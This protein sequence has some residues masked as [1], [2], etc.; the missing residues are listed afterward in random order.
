METS[1]E[2]QESPM[3]AISF[4]FHD[5]VLNGGHEDTG[6]GGAHADR[7][8]ITLS[9]FEA[10]LDAM[11][12]ARAGKPMLVSDIQH[13]VSGFVPIFLTFDDGGSS[14]YTCIADALEKRG[15]RGHFF[16]TTDYIG[17]SGFLNKD[18][19]RVLH[20]KGH[21]IGTHSCSHPRRMSYLAWDMLLQ[22]WS[23]SVKILS[24]IIGRPVKSGSVPGGYFSRRVA[25]AAAACGLTTLF[26]SEP[27]T[28][29][30][31]VEN[32]MVIGRFSVIKGSSAKVTWNLTVGKWTSH[33]QCV[34]KWNV[35]KLAKFVLG[36]QYLA[37]QTALLN[38]RVHTGARPG[39]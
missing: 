8:K 32:C 29:C 14:A 4:L 13:T 21:V 27:R 11:L 16:V 30:Y 34:L 17:G 18:Q 28:G 26:T 2:T 9:E 36:K 33:M 6:F 31:H 5:V 15:L 20:D 35:K 19:I 38:R 12:D 39:S 7:Y 10:H 23:Q 24:E 22:E 37:L 3:R 25:K 1:G